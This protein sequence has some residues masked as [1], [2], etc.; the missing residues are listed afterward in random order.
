M[1]SATSVGEPLR[2]A[3]AFPRLHLIL[4]KIGEMENYEAQAKRE[5][6]NDLLQQSKELTDAIRNKGEELIALLERRAQELQHSKTDRAALAGLFNEVALRLTDQFKVTGSRLTHGFRTVQPSVRTTSP[7]LSCAPSSSARIALRGSPCAS[8]WTIRL[9]GPKMWPACWP[10]R[11]ALGPAGTPISSCAALCS[12]CSKKRSSF[13]C[14]PI[15]ACWRTP[16]SPSSA[17][18]FARRSHPSWT[19]CSSH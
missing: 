5:I 4:K 3:A 11:C 16:C 14:S 7:S 17:R 9:A 10:R 15:R 1:P 19:A 2:L 13:P 12:R 8:A 18:P 6:R